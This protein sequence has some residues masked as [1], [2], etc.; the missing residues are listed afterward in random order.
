MPLASN[1]NSSGQVWRWAVRNRNPLTLRS[2]RVCSQS[3]LLSQGLNSTSPHCPS[4]QQ[5]C[6]WWGD[7][8]T[9]ASDE[10]F[11]RPTS[12]T[13]VCEGCYG[14]QLQIDELSMHP[15]SID[16]TLTFHHSNKEKALC[17]IC[18]LSPSLAETKPSSEPWQSRESITTLYICS[19]WPT[20]Y[21]VFLY[22]VMPCCTL[23]LCLVYAISKLKRGS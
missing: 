1:S 17:A 20:Y 2:A 4:Q 5:R 12:N 3:V 15:C 21:P 7:K 10:L 19:N 11:V 22:S 8:C 14:M 9:Y 6:E 16:V 18:Y 23:G 13:I